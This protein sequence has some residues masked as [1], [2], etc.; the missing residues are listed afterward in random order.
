MTAEEF[1]LSK[2]RNLLS[3]N[4]AEWLEMMNEYLNIHISKMKYDIHNLLPNECLDDCD[5]K[6]C[7]YRNG[8]GNACKRCSDLK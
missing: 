4:H 3:F 5:I 1:V 6:Y 2:G 7:S 8:D